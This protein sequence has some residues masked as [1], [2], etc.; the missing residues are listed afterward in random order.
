M[1][2]CAACGDRESRLVRVDLSGVP[3]GQP[4]H[5]V[6]HRWT[7]LYA[8]PGCDAGRLVVWA[9]WGRSSG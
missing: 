1:G 7:D 2:G 8:C 3:H 6:Y 4:G 5:R 9:T